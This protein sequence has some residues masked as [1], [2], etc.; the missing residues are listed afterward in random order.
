MLTGNSSRM[1]LLDQAL[2]GQSAEVKARVQNILLR[3]NIDVENEFFLIFTAIGH[4]LAIVEESPE[5]WRSLFDDVHQELML[6]SGENFKSLESIKLH[7][8]TSAELIAVLR[9]LL[10]SMQKSQNSSQATS[11][12][13]LGLRTTLSTISLDLSSLKSKSDS[14]ERALSQIDRQIAASTT[15]LNQLSDGSNQ[16]QNQLNEIVRCLNR[17][18][19]FERQRRTRGWISSFSLAGLVLLSS[20]MAWNNWMM[21][22][23]LGQQRLTLRQ[24]REEMGWLLEKANRAECWYGIKPPDNPQCQ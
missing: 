8:Q 10:D 24:Q 4:L 7:A 2:A 15:Q 20:A 5:N 6:W 22:K 9:Q 23:E 19:E 17:L 3:Y 21:S 13:L 14:R 1:K 18:N 11:S 16:R 12:S